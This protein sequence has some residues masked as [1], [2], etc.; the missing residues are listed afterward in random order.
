MRVKCRL[1]TT[2]PGPTDE[3]WSG[4]KSRHDSGQD[5]QEFRLQMG[6]KIKAHMQGEATDPPRLGAG[7]DRH[8]L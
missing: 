5:V 6:L 1:W 4:V 2:A 3:D 8:D 7:L